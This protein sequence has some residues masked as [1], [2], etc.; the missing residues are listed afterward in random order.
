MRTYFKI[1]SSLW[2]F[3]RGYTIEIAVEIVVFSLISFFFC[4]SCTALAASHLVSCPPLPWVLKNPLRHP[5]QNSVNSRTLSLIS[6]WYLT[7]FIILYYVNLKDPRP[8]TLDLS[9]SI[10]CRFLIHCKVAI[11]LLRKASFK[12]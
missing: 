1:F 8:L 5:I 4:C 2:E 6:H 12:S 3:S 10:F 9:F 11:R 7:P